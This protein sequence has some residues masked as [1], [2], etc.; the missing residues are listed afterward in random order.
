MRGRNH[1]PPSAS[2]LF[3]EQ[4]AEAAHMLLSH[5]STNAKPS[6]VNAFKHRPMDQV[7]QELAQ[8]GN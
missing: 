2:F 3:I 5:G 6:A 7:A 4:G 1:L 8:P